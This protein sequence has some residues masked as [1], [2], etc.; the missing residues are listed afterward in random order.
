MIVLQIFDMK[1][2]GKQTLLI[3]LVLILVVLNLGLVTFMWYTQ[4]PESGPLGH[5][6][7]KFLIRELNFDKGQEEKYIQLQQQLGDSLF[8]TRERERQLHDRFFEMM[9][10]ASPDSMQ[11]ALIIDSMGQTRGRIEYFTFVHFRQVRAL[12][13]AEQQQKFDKVIGDAMRRMGPPPPPGGR[14]RPEGGPPLPPDR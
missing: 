13:N 3:I 6:T 8:N 7:A 4:R 11:V 1:P 9:H 5:S 14:R 10:E 12:C 2:V